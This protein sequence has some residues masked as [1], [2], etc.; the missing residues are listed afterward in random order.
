MKLFEGD[1]SVKKSIFYLITLI[2]ALLGV[3]TPLLA[4]IVYHS[5]K[6]VAPIPIRDPSEAGMWGDGRELIL[7]FYGFGWWGLMIIL[8]VTS[9][10]IGSIRQENGLVK[11]WAISIM[12][13]N[14]VAPILFLML[15]LFF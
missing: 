6:F 3:A 8:S 15:S 14:I 7:T 12:L 2:T 1:I 9:A 4:W 11:R 13:V 5:W 10:I